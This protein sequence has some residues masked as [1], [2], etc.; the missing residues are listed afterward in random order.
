MFELTPAAIGLILPVSFLISAVAVVIT[1]MIVEG[2][3]KELYHKERIIAMEKGI[4]FPKIEEKKK[5]PRYLAMRA[6][7]LVIALLSIG[8]I[9]GLL[10]ELGFRGALWGLIPLGLGAGLIISAYMEKSETPE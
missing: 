8:L 1:A 9:I 6:W 5:R 4:E 2:R 3:K 10:G 7:G